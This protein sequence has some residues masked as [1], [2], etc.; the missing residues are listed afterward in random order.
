[1][2]RGTIII[3]IIQCPV[4]VLK[5]IV[6]H[7]ERGDEF[8]WP[9]NTNTYGLVSINIVSLSSAGLATVLMLKRLRWSIRGHPETQTKLN[10]GETE[11][12]LSFSHLLQ[13]YHIY[14]EQSS[15]AAR[16]LH[17]KHTSHRHCGEFKIQGQLLFSSTRTAPLHKYNS[18]WSFTALAFTQCWV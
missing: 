6:L 2:N 18:L 15:T 8:W 5:S 7:S 17:F 16:R 10:G 12:S 1:M 4:P 11:N 13:A 9:G 14:R 3:N